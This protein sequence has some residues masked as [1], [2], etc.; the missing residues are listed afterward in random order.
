MKHTDAIHGSHDGEYRRLKDRN[1]LK[2]RWVV[3]SCALR[4]E[5]CVPLDIGNLTF[6]IS[7][8]TYTDYGAVPYSA[9][10][11]S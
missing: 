10:A 3:T 8:S 2:V 4:P 6:H 1:G 9:L 7:R 11:G 5:G